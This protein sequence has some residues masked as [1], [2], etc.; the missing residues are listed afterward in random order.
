VPERGRDKKSL[1][2]EAW[3]ELFDIIIATAD[4]R[5]RVLEQLGLTPND[6]RALGSLDPERARTMRSLAE[7]WRCDASTATWIV[8]RL[9]QRGLVERRSVPQDRRVTLVALTARGVTTKTKMIRGMYTPPRELQRLTNDELAALR[10][11][12]SRL[13][14]VATAAPPRAAPRRK[15]SR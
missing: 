14:A 12:A 10:D 1:A 11:A 13:R 5:G 2:A 4:Q 8:D 7:E 3:R 15:V 6:S 9:E